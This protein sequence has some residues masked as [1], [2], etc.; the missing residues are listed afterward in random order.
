MKKI[1]KQLFK[2]TS[3]SLHRSLLDWLKEPDYRAQLFVESYMSQI[4]N[5]LKENEITYKE[6]AD[7]LGVTKS[8]VTQFLDANENISVNRLFKY[9]DVLGL[10]LQEPRLVENDIERIYEDYKST[11]LK[12]NFAKIHPIDNNWATLSEY[13][14]EE[15]TS[16]TGQVGEDIERYREQV[17]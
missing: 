7:K 17:A 15:F 16:E 4:I 14:D 12:V 9:A 1:I 8:S 13:A 5:Y 3:D 2:K 10:T 11:D 6:F